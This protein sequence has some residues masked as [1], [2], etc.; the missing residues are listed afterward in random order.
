MF[1]FTSLELID[2]PFF[3]KQ[4]FDFSP[5]IKLILG[6]NQNSSEHNSNAAG[7]SLFF[8][9][10]PELLLNEV[11]HGT[12]R[13]QTR[14]G[15]VRVS[16]TKGKNSYVI[17]RTFSPREKISIFR[18]GEDMDIHELSK[19]RSYIEKIVP[20]SPQEVNTFLYLDSQLPHPLITGDTSARK[21]FFTAFF[22]LE[23]IPFA[24]KTINAKIAELNAAK[25]LYTDLRERRADLKSKQDLSL[26]KKK[27][28]LDNLTAQ[29]ADLQSVMQDWINADAVRKRMHQ[30]KDALDL[31]TELGIETQSGLEKTVRDYSKKLKE[32]S[33]TI[34]RWEDYH[35]W[36]KTAPSRVAAEKSLLED[37]QCSTLEAAVAKLK[38]LQSLIKDSKAEV[39]SLE[40]QINSAD[41]KRSRLTSSLEDLEE[42]RTR[43]KADLTRLKEAKDTCPTCGSAFDNKHAATEL[44]RVRDKLVRIRE[45][46]QDTEEKLASLP[47]TKT[48][49]ETLER[50]LATLSKDKDNYST[51]DQLVE[52]ASTVSP[53]KPEVSEEE[54]RVYYEEARKHLSVLERAP[55]A[56]EAR[57]DWLKLPKAIRKAST[58]DFQTKQ[59]EYMKLV[60]A[61]SQLEVEVSRA[62]DINTE[63][64][65]VLEKLRPLRKRLADREA[66]E[67]LEGAFSRKGVESMLIRSICESLQEQVNK[68]SKL[69]F[70]EDY[71]FEFELETQFS[72]LVHRKYGKEKY[73]SDVRKLSGA[74]RKLFSLVL[75]V[76][77]LTFVPKSRRTS[78]LILDEPTAAMG[79]E[80]VANFVRFLPILQKVIPTIVVI[81][82][83]DPSVYQSIQPEVFTVVK[84]R[85]GFST[86]EKG[87][88]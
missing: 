79:K 65:D 70:P 9:Q 77:L 75:L 40:D 54:A 42:D 44:D 12:S 16:G 67:L 36:K 30:Y 52:E 7:K 56:L 24:K 31:L 60:S 49:K 73:V 39:A 23:V 1:Q 20:Y 61:K 76:S 27:S 63:L 19:A 10:L 38:S 82:P 48:L 80:N 6:K 2:R 17:E 4:S 22:R 87:A 72:I 62:D 57:E 26:D 64:A 47:Q 55:S 86:I 78:L 5:G 66:L 71:R 83:L 51:L 85:N 53:D 81:T 41:G 35:E 59:T 14:Q 69:I 58:E 88:V 8:S 15:T 74:E 84:G 28:R 50:K 68:Y 43:L 11:L 37:F 46:R 25:L 29:A 3:K 21:K 34:H 13:D 45:L 33:R 32:A 18:N